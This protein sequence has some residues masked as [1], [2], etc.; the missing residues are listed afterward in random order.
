METPAR[1]QGM[2]VLN[3]ARRFAYWRAKRVRARLDRYR[4]ERFAARRLS[5]HWLETDPSIV[6]PSYF[7]TDSWIDVE[8]LKSLD[9]EI[10]TGARACL[11]ESQ[12]VPFDA[13][14]LHKGRGK[15]GRQPGSTNLH[16]TS[17]GKAFRY[18]DLE[19]CDEWQLTPLAERFPGLMRFVETLPFAQT[20]RILIMCDDRGREVTTHRD[21]AYGAILHQFLWFRT[22]LDK[23]FFVTDRHQK[24][25]KY[26]Q[27]HS[28]WFDT[29]NQ[30][31]GADAADRMT[32]SL[33]VDGVFRDD[34]RHQ[35]P[36][37]PSNVA[38]TPSYWATLQAKGQG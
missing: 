16:L 25:R 24:E 18:Y 33:R 26:L 9:E 31:H 1:M 37:P 35:L 28:A 5:K 36:D 27:S 14:A 32:L 34:F 30:F 29:V 13:G 23:P 38:S 20:S 6:Y 21:H 15:R 12:G 17:N 7:S 19:A 4:E 11:Q 8:R 22:N 2:G 10:V 3:R